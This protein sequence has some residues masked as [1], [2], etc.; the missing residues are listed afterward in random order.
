MQQ[1]SMCSKSAASWGMRPSRLCCKNAAS[2]PCYLMPE[3]PK[4]PAPRSVAPSSVTWMSTGC[5]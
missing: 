4:P 3:C 1:S 2:W 5:S